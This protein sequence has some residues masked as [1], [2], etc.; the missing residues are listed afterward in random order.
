MNQALKPFIHNKTLQLEDGL[1]TIYYPNY[2]A[3]TDTTMA[4]Y[5]V[6]SQ[7]GL[8]TSYYDE[9][10]PGK[11]FYQAA[12]ANGK[13]DD[14]YDFVR[15]RMIQTYNLFMG[16]RFKMSYTIPGKP[17]REYVSFL[18]SN[19]DPIEAFN[20]SVQLETQLVEEGVK[21]QYIHQVSL[22]L[23]FY[24]Y[25]I[26]TAAYYTFDFLN[27][28]DVGGGFSKT[29][30]ELLFMPRVNDNLSNYF[31]TQILVWL[32]RGAY[33]ISFILFVYKFGQDLF[34]M[35]RS[36]TEVISEKLS[37]WYV[38]YAVYIVINSKYFVDYL[39]LLASPLL[40]T[41]VP[42]TTHEQFDRWIDMAQN[43]KAIMVLN[44][45]LTILLITRI[46]EMLSVKFRSVL[47]LVFFSFS[48]TGKYLVAYFIVES[49]NSVHFPIYCLLCEL[50]SLKH[51]HHRAFIQQH[52]LDHPNSSSLCFPRHSIS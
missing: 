44:G 42:V 11:N 30:D 21:A 12:F 9:P 48:T 20:Q 10:E 29:A 51:E 17:K 41:G 36:S 2:E 38:I 7:V 31:Y 16:A 15:W 33:L 5:F 47:T 52:R 27:K 50:R 35:L 19:V 40:Y 13:F 25:N 46:M 18:P 45:L 39:Y 26:E 37:F 28:G 14:I 6:Y 22:E 24:N 34:L 49:C 32:I 8:I 3:V 43:Q 23:L 4:Y 1:G